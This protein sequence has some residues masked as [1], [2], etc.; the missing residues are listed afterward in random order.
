MDFDS[1]IISHNLEQLPK[2]KKDKY[3]DCAANI[4]V[5][6]SKPFSL[7]FCMKNTLNL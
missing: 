1:F 6:K 4:D 3:I 7:I 5:A 2:Q